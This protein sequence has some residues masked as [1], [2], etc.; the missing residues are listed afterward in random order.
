MTFLIS[1][2][3]RIFQVTWFFDVNLGENF[4]RKAGFVADGHKMYTPSSVTYSTF[5][6]KDLVRMC[7]IFAALNNVSVLAADI[8]NAY[9]TDPCE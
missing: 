6:S 5:F 3:S 4:L 8:D 9:L 7:L 1:S 2:V